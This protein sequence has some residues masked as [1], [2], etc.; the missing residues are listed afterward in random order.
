MDFE[1]EKPELSISFQAAI[2]YSHYGAIV[3]NFYQ[4]ILNI[5]LYP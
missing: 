2:T 4:A 3:F 5:Y 1:S